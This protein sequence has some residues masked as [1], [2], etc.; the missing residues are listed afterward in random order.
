MYTKQEN[1]HPGKF[2]GNESQHIA[3][4]LHDICGNG[5]HCEEVSTLSGGWVAKIK[6]KRNMF[7]VFED[8]QGFFEYDIYYT[9]EDGLQAWENIALYFELEYRL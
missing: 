5:G 4:V 3:T 6:G 2:E 7:I 8:T 9:L 1:R